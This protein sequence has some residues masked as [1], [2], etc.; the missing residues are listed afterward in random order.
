[1]KNRTWSGFLV[2]CGSLLRTNGFET[3][4]HCSSVGNHQY[5]LKSAGI[6]EKNN[7]KLKTQ[8]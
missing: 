3:Q 6:V 1:M 4:I 8:L 7:E 5:I 2:S